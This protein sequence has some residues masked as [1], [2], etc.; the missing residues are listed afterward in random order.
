MKKIKLIIISLLISIGFLFNGELFVL[1]LDYFQNA[2][3]QS[4]LGRDFVPI[5]VVPIQTL[6]KFDIISCVEQR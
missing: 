5:G 2:Y 1:Y 4:G 3:Y 6:P